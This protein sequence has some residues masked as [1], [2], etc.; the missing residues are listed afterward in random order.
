MKKAEIDLLLKA[1]G[2]DL[3]RR[4]DTPF[5]LEYRF[6]PERKWRFDGCFPLRSIAVEIEG[7]VWVRGRHVSPKGYIRDCE[8][9]NAAGLLGYKVFRFV[10]K[11]LKDGEVY[12]VLEAAWGEQKRR[13]TNDKT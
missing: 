9:Y 8:K 13:Q 1:T 3:A 5:E 4:F 11:Q 6:H 2:F 10:P 7:G 12:G